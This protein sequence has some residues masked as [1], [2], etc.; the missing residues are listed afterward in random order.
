MNARVLFLLAHPDDEFACSMWMKHLVDTGSEVFC[1]YLTDGGYGGQSVARR[2]AESRRALAMLG[3]PPARI[4]FIGSE[5][6]IGDGSLPAALPRAQAALEHWLA[7]QGP[8]ERIVVPA[9]EGG[10]QD[11]D[12]VHVLGVLLGRRM[13]CAVE[14][15]PLYNGYRLPG[16]L[17]RVLAPL[18]GNGPVSVYRPGWRGRLASIR[19]CFVHRSQWRS[20]LGLLPFF[21]L[22]MAVSGVFPRQPARF[23]RLLERP[24]PGPLLYERRGGYGYDRFRG[25]VKAFMTVNAGSGTGCTAI[26]KET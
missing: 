1:A 12:A 8:V 25:E 26:A 9:W 22:H 21:A 5:Q 3:L 7:G 10:H 16:P 2:E 15:F 11:H 23:E 14:Q 24:H 18:A 17:F 6:G 4:G 19:L 20:W 13:G